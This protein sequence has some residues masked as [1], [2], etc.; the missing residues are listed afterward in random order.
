MGI[1]GGPLDFFG[2]LDSEDEEDEERSPRHE[3]RKRKNDR[4]CLRNLLLVGG[5][6]FAAIAW[7]YFLGLI[8]QY[9]YR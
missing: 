2:W 7:C 9:I 1:G 4:S 6:A 3:V 5:L 8:L